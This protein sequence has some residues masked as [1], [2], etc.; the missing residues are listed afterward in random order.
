[1]NPLKEKLKKYALPVVVK[2]IKFVQGILG[3]EAGIKGS[4]GLFI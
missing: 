3:N 4:I 2:D 1:M